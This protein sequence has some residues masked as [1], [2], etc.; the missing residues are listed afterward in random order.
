MVASLYSTVNGVASKKDA[1]LTRGSMM[2]KSLLTLMFQT[3][4]RV[5][6]EQWSL[7]THLSLSLCLVKSQYVEREVVIHSKA[8]N[9]QAKTT[10]VPKVPLHA[11]TIL[12]LRIL[13]A[14]L[15]TRKSLSV[16][17]QP[18]LSSLP[19]AS[20]HQIQ[21]RFE[22]QINTASFFL[23]LLLIISQLQ[24]LKW[25]SKIHACYLLRLFA[26]HHSTRQK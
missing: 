20:V 2:M 1:F 23:R 15:R 6:E 7:A 4:N 19:Q 24:P 11:Q 13:C 16:Q 12:L 5:T 3:R 10:N 22:S 25:H 26:D 8:F 14:T 17:L 18:S 9:G 21:M